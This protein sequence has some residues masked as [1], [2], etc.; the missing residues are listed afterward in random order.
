MPRRK[1][2]FRLMNN[3]LRFHFKTI[4]FQYSMGYER[5]HI[6]NSKSYEILFLFILCALA[7]LR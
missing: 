6:L 1:A 3:M 7:P 4:S 5:N 2:S